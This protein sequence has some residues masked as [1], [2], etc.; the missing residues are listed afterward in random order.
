MKRL[1][2][3]AWPLFLAGCTT[4]QY[5]SSGEMAGIAPALSVERFLRATNAR[6]LHGM[7]RIFGT[8]KGPYIETGGPVGCA[9]KKLGSWIGI[10]QRCSTI[11]EV[12]LRMD[13]IAE[14]LRHDDY[15]LVSESSVPGRV[16]PTSRIGVDLSIRG[17]TIPDVP[18]FVVRSKEGRWLV[19]QIGLEKITGEAPEP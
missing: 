14:V 4:T 10:G 6:D 13:A 1:I 2:L 17:R 19:E 9:F 3:A 5:V 16:A 18:F 11:Q 12:E 7:A 15:A 8:E